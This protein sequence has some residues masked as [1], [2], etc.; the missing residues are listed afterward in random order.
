[1]RIEFPFVTSTPAAVFRRADT[2]WLVFDSDATVDL[3][4][5]KREAGDAIREAHF[6]RS[7][8]GAAMVRL[9]L[10]RPRLTGVINDGPAWIVD[11]GDNVIAPTK[12]LSIARSIAGK[13]RA[14]IAIPFDDARK[15]HRITDPAVGD[16]LMVITALAPARGFLKAQ[17]FVELRALPSAH[18]VVLQPLADDLTAELSAD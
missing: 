1:M 12:P 4:A 10:A 17:D 8:D 16:N 15:V 5:V 11:V 13:N 7:K 3:T 14:S 9:R 6:D 2:L 18:G